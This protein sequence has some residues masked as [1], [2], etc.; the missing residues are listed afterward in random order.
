MRGITACVCAIAAVAGLDAAQLV[1]RAGVDLA[2]PCGHDYRPDGRARHR[3]HAGRLRGDRGRRNPAPGTL[4][5]GGGEEAIAAAA[6][7]AD[8]RRQRQH[9][10]RHEAR[11]GRRDQVPEHAARVRG[12]HARGL[13]HAGADHAVPAARLSRGW[14][15]GFASARPTAGPRSTTPS[16]S[17]WTAPTRQD[18]R[19]VLVMYTDGGDSRSSLSLTETV[20]LL[21]ASQRHRLRDRTGREYRRRTP[22]IAADGCGSSPKRPAARPSFRAA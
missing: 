8:G 14:S 16:A 12:H 9:G 21:K 6:P 10:A 17:I 22:G 7:R 5:P 15:S 13:R 3:P 18:G 19:K 1:F 4:R 11:A 2:T 20:T